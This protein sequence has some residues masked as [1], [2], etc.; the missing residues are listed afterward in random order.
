MHARYIRHQLEY[1]L[2]CVYDI[3]RLKAD[4]GNCSYDVRKMTTAKTGGKFSAVLWLFASVYEI[5]DQLAYLLDQMGY[6]TRRDESFA[7]RLAL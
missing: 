5:I 7:C 4:H 1:I 2:Y 6:T 3:H